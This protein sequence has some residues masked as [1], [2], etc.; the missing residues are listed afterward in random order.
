MEV[1]LCRS[2]LLFSNVNW[3]VTDYSF[4]R[5]CQ[6]DN[7]WSV[8]CDLS[9]GFSALRM[10]YDCHIVRN[11]TLPPWG[12]FSCCFCFHFWDCCLIWSWLYKCFLKKKKNCSQ[13]D[14]L[15]EIPG[16]ELKCEVKMQIPP[17]LWHERVYVTLS[18]IVMFTFETHFI[19]L[20]GQVL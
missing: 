9:P 1:R 20:H 2:W 17:I 15:F 10:P 8:I 18:N 6:K 14:V 13:Q 11:G 7:W 19:C 3:F 12:L 5:L 4:K 16:K